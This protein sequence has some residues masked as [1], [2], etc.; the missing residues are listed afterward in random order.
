MTT[1]NKEQ[2]AEILN[3]RQYRNEMTKEEEKLAKENGLLVCF[4]ASD[5]LLEFR[6]IVYNEVEAYDGG[7]ALLVRKKGDKIDVIGEDDLKEVE[8][9]MDD[10]ELVFDLPKVEVVAEWRPDDLKCYWRIK[11]DLPHSTFDIMDDGELYCR[12]IIIDK[13]DIERSLY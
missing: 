10:K 2:L 9:I 7:T 8:E 6:G 4:G 12:G 3:G 13:S 11:S 1:I 5:D